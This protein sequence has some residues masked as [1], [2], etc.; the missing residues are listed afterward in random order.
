MRKFE[1]FMFFYS[2]VAVTVLA[3]SSAIFSPGPQ[4]IIAGIAYL[5]IFVFFWLRLTSPN[6]T[7]AAG[8]SARLAVVAVLL[9]ALGFYVV[10]LSSSAKYSATKLSAL[11]LEKSELSAKNIQ[12]EDQNAQLKKSTEEL[13]KLS[14]SFNDLKDKLSSGGYSLDYVLGA[15]GS[16]D[17]SDLLLDLKSGDQDTALELVTMTNKE[18]KNAPVMAKASLTSDEIGKI[19]YGE[20]YPYVAI[21]GSWYNIQLPNGDLGWVYDRDVHVVEADEN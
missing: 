12:L 9:S 21:D 8:W 5:P 6:D 11:E 13:T 3:I 16:A 14:D 20:D 19:I 18:L 17:L 2:L 15:S 7:D 4:N 1:K 10:N